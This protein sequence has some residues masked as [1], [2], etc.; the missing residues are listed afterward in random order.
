[1]IYNNYTCIADDRIDL[2]VKN[3][4]GT[5]DNLSLVLENNPNLLKIS[6]NLKG[7]TVVKLPVIEE[8]SFKN[9]VVQKIARKPLW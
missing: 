9:A 7:G 1:M 6:M 3:H 2:I 4:Y 8:K 5:I